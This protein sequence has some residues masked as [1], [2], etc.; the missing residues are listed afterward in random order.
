MVLPPAHV[1]IPTYMHLATRTRIYTHTYT[2][3]DMA[4]LWLRNG[5]NH[6]P[7]FLVFFRPFFSYFLGLLFLLGGT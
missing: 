6:F 3:A 4:A 2:H 1:R 7:T 5:L